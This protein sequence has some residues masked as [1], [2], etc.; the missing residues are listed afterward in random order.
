MLSG[1]LPF[2]A[3]HSFDFM[4]AH[5]REEPRPLQAQRPDIPDEVAGL[6][7]SMLV[8]EPTERPTMSSVVTL[9]DQLQAAAET[10]WPQSQGS[11]PRPRISRDAIPK[12][13]YPSGA[14]SA[15][16]RTGNTPTNREDIEL[17]PTLGGA[18]MP[19]ISRDSLNAITPA[20]ASST[21][22]GSVQP[23]ASGS[24]VIPVPAGPGRVRGVI[25][26]LGALVLIGAVMVAV[27]LRRGPMTSAQRGPEQPLS[28]PPV[29]RKVKWSVISNPPGAEVV[30]R[31]GH[32]L[33]STPWQL[34]RP[35]D[36]GETVITLRHA[37]FQDKQI[38]LSHS[39]DLSTEVTLVAVPPPVAA[40]AEPGSAE[41]G[42]V[43]ADAK[44]KKTGKQRKKKK[45]EDVK[46]LI[47]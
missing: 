29:E 25:A 4:A 2:T 40:P 1:A 16:L 7:H 28:R 39:T 23:A 21:R 11:S 10:L 14:R 20:A 47:D 19:R 6:V 32:V 46:L 35:A 22:S 42:T 31:D 38:L 37:G 12:L 33:G 27:L 44:Q 8:K 41:P 36:P 9:L 43:A 30:R 34:E 45:D 18:S 3:Q 5:L 17:S 15:G 26:V 24:A 13:S